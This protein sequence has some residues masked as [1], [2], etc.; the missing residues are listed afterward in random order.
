MPSLPAPA[1]PGASPE[2]STA[3]LDSLAEIV[4]HTDGEGRWTYLNR[5]W[6]DIL[7][8]AVD[9]SL[10]RPFLDF[11][12]PDERA[13]TLERVAV[14]AS[15]RAEVCHHTTRFLT[16]RGDARWVELRARAVRDETGRIVANSGTIID[17]SDR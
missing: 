5:A 13:D 11:I 7:G 6:T 15:G 9:E 4:F 2:A 3:L 17:V 10:G 12:H 8:H 14:V 1:L 16:A